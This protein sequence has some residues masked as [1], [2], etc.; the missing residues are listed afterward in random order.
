L[1]DPDA[2]ADTLAPEVQT[3]LVGHEAVRS[4]VRAQLAAGRLP[5]A[6]LL[7]GPQGIGKATL[8]FTLA[9]DILTATGDEDAHRVDEQ[10]AA[11][12]HP[13]LA[14]LRRRPRDGK[15]Y[16]TVIRVEDVRELREE[17]HMTRGRAGHR[18]AIVDPIDDCNANAANALLKTLEE[19]PPET[20]FLLVSHRPGQLLPTIHSRCHS[21]AL[22]ALGDTDVSTVLTAQRPDAGVDEIARAVGFARGRPRRGFEALALSPESVLGGLQTWLQA[23]LRHPS[24]IHLA[25]ADAIGADRDGPDLSFARELLNDWLAEE[26]K[27]AAISGERM[28]LA[29]AGEL[30]EKADALFAETDALNLDMRQTLV[31]IFDA[32]RKHVQTTSSPATQQ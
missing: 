32:I 27:A 4:A 29:S 15:G 18:V 21:L 31:T 17:L 22:R 14:V 16:Y 8:A 10:V 6:V 28:R 23:P 9:R 19:P 12:A 3:R 5:G 1:T 13:N 24:A 26:A 20:T 30:W 7:H 25:L 11:G 2:I